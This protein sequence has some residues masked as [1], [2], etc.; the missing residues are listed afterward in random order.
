[1]IINPELLVHVDMSG[2]QIGEGDFVAVV[3][4]RS[5]TKAL[6]QSI[7]EFSEDMLR[8]R[9]IIKIIKYALFIWKTFISMT[10]INKT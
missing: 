10:A 3:G 4:S 5:Q 6:Q 2:S 7:C 9:N 1:M 8:V